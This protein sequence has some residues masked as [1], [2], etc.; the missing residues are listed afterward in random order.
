MV[1]TA[2]CLSC[3]PSPPLINLSVYRSSRCGSGHSTLVHILDSSCH[4]YL[5]PPSD[6][7]TIFL[8]NPYRSTWPL[9]EGNYLVDTYLYVFSG[10][11]LLSEISSFINKLNRHK[12]NFS[13]HRCRFSKS[14]GPKPIVGYQAPP[15]Q[16]EL[17]PKVFI[18]MIF[19]KWI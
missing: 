3:F 2:G 10:K 17:T 14:S 15:P 18:L 8:F 5:K 7:L 12:N 19:G 9:T 13:Y 4:H 11:L 6:K 1:K 16:E